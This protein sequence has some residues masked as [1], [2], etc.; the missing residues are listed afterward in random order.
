M[1]RRPLFRGQLRAPRH[2]LAQGQQGPFRGKKFDL[3]R[4]RWRGNYKIADKL[5][6]KKSFSRPDRL[7][8]LLLGVTKKVAK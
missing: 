2:V 4:H 7:Q 6:F 8:N 5:V 3:V 1:P